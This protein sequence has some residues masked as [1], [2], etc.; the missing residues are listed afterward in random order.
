MRFRRAD[1][2]HRRRRG[3]T[4]QQQFEI[5]RGGRWIPKL[6]RNG[7]ALLSQANVAAQRAMRQRF[8]ESSLRNE[9]GFT[10]GFEEMVLR[11]WRERWSKLRAVESNNIQDTDS[12]QKLHAPAADAR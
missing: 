6:L 3:D 4:C 10:R 7:L 8:E 2:M 12:R 9:Q 5:V 1:G 11:A